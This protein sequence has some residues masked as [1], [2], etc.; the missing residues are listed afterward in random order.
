MTTLER[1]RIEAGAIPSNAF[2]GCTG[3]TSVELGDGVTAIGD[4]AFRYCTGL[5]S[6]T[7]P[8]SVTSCGQSILYGCTNLRYLYVGGNV[9]LS[10]SDTVGNPFNIGSGSNLE[11]LV[12]GEGITQI[13]AYRFTNT[14]GSGYQRYYFPK[15]TTVVFPSTLRLIG[16]CAFQGAPLKELDF[17]GSIALSSSAF[18]GMTTLERVRI[19]AGAIPSCAFENCTGLTSVELGDGVT[20]IGDNA[21]RDCTGLTSFTIPDSVT[22]CGPGILF[23]CTNLR[24]LYIG[25][26]V[27]LPSSSFTG[28]PFYI[29]SGSK[30]ETL[31]LGE[32]I[33][34]IGP[35]RLSN[36]YSNSGSY[37]HYG[38]PELTT[39]ILPSTLESLYSGNLSYW[40]QVRHLAFG[41]ALTGIAES[42]SVPA[43]LTLYSDGQNAAL[44]AFAESKGLNYV[45]GGETPRYTLRLLVPESAA[46]VGASLEESD[47]PAGFACLSE[48]ERSFNSALLPEAPQVPAGC[49]FRGWY[50]DS[51]LTTPL[52]LGVMP[53]RELTL[54]AKIDAPVE[55]RYLVPD[56]SA[57][58]GWAVYESFRLLAG[59]AMPAPAQTPERTHSRFTG[60]YAEP[61]CVTPWAL[62][63]V[64]E[65]GADVY[66]GFEG[67]TRI[68]FAVNNAAAGTPDAGLPGGFYRYASYELPVGSAFPW[69]ADPSAEGYA[70]EGWFDSPALK[71][72]YARRVVGSEEVVYYGKLSRLTPGG[73]Y[74]S[75]PGGLKLVSYRVEEDGSSILHLPSRVNGLPVV[76]IG[77]FAFTAGGVDTLCLPD[78]LRS[79]DPEAFT[80]SGIFSLVIGR[81]AENFKTVNGVLFSKDGTELLYYPAARHSE[82]YA[83]PAGVTR[84]AAR[85]FRNNPYLKSVIF[86][87]TLE[88][89]GAEAFSGCAALESVSLPA[90]TTT[91]RAGAFAGCA[92]LE[93]F[94][95]YGLTT[96]ESGANGRVETI[97]RAVASVFGPL[98]EGV[99]RDWFLYTSSGGAY[100]FQYNQYLLTLSLDDE[101]ETIT[102]EAGLPLTGE[103]SDVR[104]EDGSFVEAWYRDEALTLPWDLAADTMPAAALTLYGTRTPLYTYENGTVTVGETE[105]TGLILTGYNGKAASLTVPAAL[106]GEAVIGLGVGFLAQNT[107]VTTLTLGAHILSI[108]EGALSGFT[109]TLV[110]D[111]DSAA[112]AWAEGRGLTLRAPQYTLRFE[113]EGE[114]VAPRQAAKGTAL[115]LP[116]LTNAY[117]GF[118][119][120]CLDAECEIPAVLDD[121]GLYTMPGADTTLYA[122]WDRE[123][124]SVPFTWTAVDGAVTITGYTGAEEDVTIPETVNGWPVT[125]V[126][127]SAF[128][129]NTHL[130]SVALG[131]VTEVGDYAF[132]DCARLRTVDFG[133]SLVSLGDGAFARCAALGSLEL[134]DSLTSLGEGAFADC[135]GLK[136]LTLGAGLESFPLNALALCERLSAVNAPAANAALS[137]VDG[138]LYNKD[139]TSLLLYP[140]GRAAES[141]AVPNGVTA[142]GESAFEGAAA[143]RTV[144]LPNSMTALGRAAFA[145]S[146][147]AS[148]T[149]SNLLEIGE[150]AFQG[151]AALTSVEPG[152]ELQSLGSMAFAGCEALTAIRLPASAVL[153]AEDIY[154]SS[155]SLVI[156]GTLGSSAHTYA[157][158]HRILFSDPDAI[159]VTAVTLNIES[160]VLERGE[161][162]QLTASLT[163]DNAND[164]TDIRWYSSDSA[165]AMVDQNGLVSAMGGGTAEIVAESANGLSA[166]CVVE[167]TVSVRELR[168]DMQSLFLT[169]EEAAQLTAEIL[170]GSATDKTLVWTS[171]DE[172]VVS[173]DENGF[174]TALAPGQTLVTA[175]AHNGLSQNVTVTVYLPA[176]PMDLNLI[177]GQR[178]RLPLPE[179]LAD[180]NGEARCALTSSGSGLSVD[181]HGVLTANDAGTYTVS[182]MAEDRELG[183]HAVTVAALNT[184]SLPAA[185]TAIEEEAFR[186]DEALERVVLGENVTGIGSRAFAETPALR[187]AVIPANVTELAPNAFENAA[188][189]LLVTENS[190]AQTFAQTLG[191]P[192]AFITED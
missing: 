176:E 118:L 89:I 74:E 152:E 191:L 49:V 17:R 190:A 46:V 42:G 145:G 139:A 143:L 179:G 102:S 174:V 148:F 115:R 82:S 81:A 159:G 71:D 146:G 153:D 192:Y 84:I 9:D 154:F 2:S 112:A 125:A 144:T 78:T 48:T 149:A 94:T 50:L 40:G 54:Y 65:G 38:F 1:V 55:V 76:S 162:L 21:F 61:S 137:S 124:E 53:P 130:E 183:R 110:C 12:L 69:P 5:T 51:A 70:F 77:A 123:T 166:S 185:L 64:P 142:L 68:V 90:S 43:G 141:F 7:I 72:S 184:L 47:L 150:N 157:Q 189:T 23:G 187:Q 93:S 95:A 11:T 134:P 8:D 37:T 168:L 161:S 56:E 136:T 119:G 3:L 178:A 147:L 105:Y 79:V 122:H 34:Q 107:T 30:L 45:V 16:A 177:P 163:P 133:E 88:E 20:A 6:F 172:S 44:A 126:G 160:M 175:T 155:P 83:I 32:G 96:I 36:T 25:G 165:V 180:G 22:S 33:T 114:T 31:V 186:G 15:L 131:A 138:V 92:A 62:D 188:P 26:N 59:E 121:D 116:T 103:L 164:G 75:V 129:G 100:S 28:N 106:G 39:V 58:E 66:A 181:D 27:D 140:R 167:V 91:L 120:W 35:Y 127:E 13:G 24:Y 86:S 151:C 128:A 182:L 99:L 104:F 60:W 10:G 169:P 57:P 73:R 158:A 67:L 173:V 87:D 80:D 97:P 41:P 18:S 171:G 156:T 132:A 135:T 170:P 98:G 85:A 113:T 29:G 101:T 117:R 19:E 108:A 63:R 4:D 14:Y 109:G 52:T 111:A